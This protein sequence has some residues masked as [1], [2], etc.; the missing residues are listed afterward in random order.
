MNNFRDTIGNILALNEPI[1]QI[2]RD[3]Q[4]AGKES[5]NLPLMLI[6]DSLGLYLG[7]AEKDSG[8][9]MFHDGRPRLIPTTLVQN[10]RVISFTRV[11]VDVIGDLVSDYEKGGECGHCGSAECILAQVPERFRTNED[12]NEMPRVCF[13]CWT[14]ERMDIV[15]DWGEDAMGPFPGIPKHQQDVFNEIATAAGMHYDT[16]IP[17]THWCPPGIEM[18][19]P[20]MNPTLDAKALEKLL[21]ESS[22][23]SSVNVECEGG[24]ET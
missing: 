6:D 13:T 14:D 12:P 22:S 16:V 23:Q 8:K 11:S 4:T 19:A 20:E 9:S 17:P 2:L 24:D 21:G 10:G 7:I 3:A 1:A 5:W 18:V 15:A